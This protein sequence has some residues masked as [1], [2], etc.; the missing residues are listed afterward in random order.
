MHDDI[1]TTASSP[2]SATSLE[3]VSESRVESQNDCSQKSRSE[4]E[5]G[6]RA[7]SEE[8]P[9][10]DLR[11]DTSWRPLGG[12]SK[13]KLVHQ[14]ELLQEELSSMRLYIRSLLG[15]VKH[16]H[17]QAD[18]VQAGSSSE[19]YMSKQPSPIKHLSGSISPNVDGGASYLA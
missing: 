12:K 1:G 17:D 19:A 11:P 9:P 7:W 4:L 13:E 5:Q 2:G 14:I 3:T 18:V 16:Q 10:A 15:G 8:D 6:R